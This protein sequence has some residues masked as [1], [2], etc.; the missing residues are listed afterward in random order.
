MYTYL[1][2][3]KYLTFSK[4]AYQE[5]MLI[6]C[7]HVFVASGLSEKRKLATCVK[8]RWVAI[9]PLKLEVVHFPINIW[10]HSN[11]DRNQNPLFFFFPPL[12]LNDHIKEL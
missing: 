12:E 3:L 8:E 9:A 6:G 2:L 7:L 10:S 11:G 4:C 5:T 1:S